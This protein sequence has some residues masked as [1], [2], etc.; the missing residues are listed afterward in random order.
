MRGPYVKGT[1]DSSLDALVVALC[2]DY[3]RRSELICA[4]DLTP[5]TAAELRYIN[6]MISAGV[7]EIAESHQVNIFIEEIGARVG[8][9]HSEI[10]GL[11]EVA[12]KIRKSEIK[13][14]I[15]KK[16]HLCE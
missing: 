14:N 16:L 8:Y 9:A 11:G 2:A 3:K 12:Y 4:K 15:A 10:F 13:R 7:A 1:L 6:Y 5:R